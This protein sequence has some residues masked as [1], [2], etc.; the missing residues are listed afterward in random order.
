MLDQHPSSPVER[1]LSAH[2]APAV[3]LLLGAALAARLVHL[4]RGLW[5][6]EYATW[7][8]ISLSWSDLLRDRFAA[9]HLPLYFALEKLWV[10]AAGSSGWVMR[11]PS[12]ALGVTGVWLALRLGE[13]GFRPAAAFVA[14]GLL[15]IDPLD[16][17]ASQVARPYAL[18]SALALFSSLQC[19]RWM[20]ARRRR[21]AVGLAM[22]T[23]AGM[24]ALPSFAFFVAG[25]AAF[26]AARGRKRLREWSEPLGALG[27]GV[28]LGLPLWFLMWGRVVRESAL[29]DPAELTL[30]HAA[31][32]VVRGIF[33][34][35]DRTRFGGW[36]SF[37][38]TC[39]LALAAGVLIVGLARN[40]AAKRMAAALSMD[41]RGGQAGDDA[42]RLT[43]YLALWVGV[44]TVL[45]LLF[46]SRVSNIAEHSRHFAPLAGAVCLSF[47]AA[48]FLLRRPA[49]RGLYLALTAGL[50]FVST[51]AWW[52]Y[53][54]DGLGDAIAWI[55]SRRQPRERVAGCNGGPIVI[56]YRYGAP[57]AARDH[58][59][60]I[61]RSI[62]SKSELR[63]RL[64]QSAGP[65]QALWLLIYHQGDSPILSVARSPAEFDIQEWRVFGD[66]QALRLKRK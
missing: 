13:E 38:G 63:R 40:N 21:N 60:S 9:G 55:E 19:M 25:Q 45:V 10:A 34:D 39:C 14:A 56:G 1:W 6:D 62:R 20:R 50:L 43:R 27:V 23:W 33:G 46:S 16:L 42:L 4:N 31:H 48:A 52:Q 65:G 51:V 57:A 22:A 36:L 28:A 37:P 11:L 58:L 32:Y 15:A 41:S 44:Y 35:V 3:V 26:L 49:W 59:D 66:A 7:S 64:Q 8:A 29:E 53:P 18:V 24:A 54:G 61:S 17:W 47:A 30:K 5:I 2:R 12:V